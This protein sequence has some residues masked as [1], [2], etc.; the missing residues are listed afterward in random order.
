MDNIKKLF[1]LVDP[2]FLNKFQDFMGLIE[3]E[4]GREDKKYLLIKDSL[5]Y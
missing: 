3:D 1:V 4:V 2:F 5:Q